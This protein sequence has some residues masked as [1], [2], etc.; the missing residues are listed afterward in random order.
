MPSSSGWH[1]RATGSTLAHAALALTANAEPWAQRS[2][3]HDCVFSRQWHARRERAA[4]SQFACL[5][6]RLISVVYSC[7][8]CQQSEWRKGGSVKEVWF[9]SRGME[10]DTTHELCDRRRTNVMLSSNYLSDEDLPERVTDVPVR[11]PEGGGVIWSIAAVSILA[12][13]QGVPP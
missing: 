6:G 12:L 10:I 3:R 8:R 13:G 4:T 7:L 1:S 9:H 5:Y 2:V 11:I